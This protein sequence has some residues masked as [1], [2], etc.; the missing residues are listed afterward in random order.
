MDMIG[1]LKYPLALMLF[2]SAFALAGDMVSVNVGPI[3]YKEALTFDYINGEIPI[4]SVSYH[5]DTEINENL[6]IIRVPQGWSY[7]QSPQ[8][9]IFSG[10]QLPNNKFI[11]DVS[12]KQYVEPGKKIFTATATTGKEPISTRGTLTI[13]ETPLLKIC[14]LVSIYRIP[15]LG[16]TFTL[17]AISSF[18]II[19]FPK[20]PLVN[21]QKKL[22]ETVFELQSKNFDNSVHKIDSAIKSIE[23]AKSSEKFQ[24][25]LSEELRTRT[26]EELNFMSKDLEILKQDLLK[27]KDNK[28]IE[29]LPFIAYISGIK[30]V[31][32]QFLKIKDYK[33][34]TSE[35]LNDEGES[36]K[37]Y[38]V[39]YISKQLGAGSLEEV[40][41]NI[42]SSSS[43]LW[44]YWPPEDYE[45]IK[46]VLKNDKIESALYRWHWQ[47]IRISNPY[48]DEKSRI[49][50]FFIPYF[51][52][53]MIRRSKEDIVFS[54]FIDCFKAIPQSYEV[55]YRKPIPEYSI[56]KG[57]K[58]KH[59]P[60]VE[61]SGWPE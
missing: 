49:H 31:L 61:Y 42:R 13:P 30:C 27:V 2:L 15:I 7:V 55:T 24:I 18:L 16:S 29:L 60:T 44:F 33:K 41:Y 19:F 12:L 57:T 38:C 11:V 8:E 3:E 35:E 45:P 28:I 23:E 58:F 54:I 39:A 52:T 43:D 21:A 17:L 25:G 46:I 59:P 37:I 40:V 4:N 53:P 14:Y 36:S 10:D 26:L 48:L 32:G 47:H 22:E 6:L 20:S 9:I 5:F 50:A 1:V 51:N 34:N 56:G